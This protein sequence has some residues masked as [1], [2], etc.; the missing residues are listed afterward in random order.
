MALNLENLDSRTRMYMLDEFQ[1]DINSD[2]LYVAAP[3]APPGRRDWPVLLQLT[4]LEGSA[5]ELADQ[6]RLGGRVD[7]GAEGGTGPHGASWDAARLLAEEQFHRFY[8]RGVCRRAIDDRHTDVEV[9]HATGDGLIDAFRHLIGLRIDARW[10]LA[11]LR[12]P[13]RASVSKVPAG[14]TCGLSIRISSPRPGPRPPQP[15][16][17]PV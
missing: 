7:P 2:T 14:P 1:R 13:P 12:L 8:C 17:A 4:L 16:P 5:V 10:L 6:L 9:Y 3:L 15:G 11:D